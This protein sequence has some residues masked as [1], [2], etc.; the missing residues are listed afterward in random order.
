VTIPPPAPATPAAE[1]IPLD[2]LYEDSHLVVVNKKAGMVVHPAPGHPSGTLVNALLFHI[3]HT[4]HSR[5][6][7]GIGGV[8]R[9]GIVHRLT[10]EP[11]E[12]GGRKRPR[13]PVSAVW[14]QKRAVEKIHSYHNG[15]PPWFRSIGPSADVTHRRKIRAARVPRAATRREEVEKLAGC[16]SLRRIHTGR[17]HQISVHLSEAGHPLVGDREYGAPRRSSPILRNFERPA[18]HA[19]RLA[20]T[21]PESGEKVSFE[22]PLPEDFRRILEELHSLRKA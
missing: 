4:R 17:T 11:R 1:A 13:P 20:F 10:R 9:P 19:F 18:L 12:Y 15:P 2:I 16:R 8:M 5:D 3:R 14:F 21:H 6:L 7:S 22:A